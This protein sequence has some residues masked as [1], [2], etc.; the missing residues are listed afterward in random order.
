MV[1]LAEPGEVD[2][3]R[4]SRA[5]DAPHA[6]IVD[7]DLWTDPGDPIAL[8]VVD[9]A[10]THFRFRLLG[11]MLS[12]TYISSAPAIQSILANDGVTGVPIGLSHTPNVPGGG[13]PTQ[14]DNIRALGI[15]DGYIT[16][17]ET[18]SDAV[19]NYRQ[20]LAAAPDGL[21]D[22]VIIG[23]HNNLRDLLQSSAD[24]ISPL[25]GLQL[26]TAKVNRL[27]V[28]G[29]QYP[30]GTEY[31]FSNNA[32]AIASAN[33]VVANWPTPIIYLGFEVG[34]TV[35]TGQSIAGRGPADLVAQAMAD[36]GVSFRMSWDAMNVMLAMDADPDSAGYR[37]VW[38]SNAVSAVTGANTF[39]PS[40][41]G[42]DR[43]VA[44]VNSDASF[45]TRINN[46]LNK[47][48]W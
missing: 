18:Y 45:Q 30:T 29:G 41:L 25:T 8:R 22:I 32:L 5:F 4:R 42:R 27:Y 20:L 21:V 23:E 6:V 47:T 46:L 40:A 3:A 26:V 36:F 1:E 48:T 16:G 15:A 2:T 19:V 17:S 9:Y 34:D 39:T 38:G 14:Y 43:Y 13:N 35:T 37:S 11:V 28:M 24:S 33:Y 10:A 12:T 31:N 7:T 44:K